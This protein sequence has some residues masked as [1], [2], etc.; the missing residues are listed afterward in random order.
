MLM[1]I[2]YHG[3]ED[4]DMS[5]KLDVNGLGVS[6]ATTWGFTIVVVGL[7]AHFTGVGASFMQS[8]DSLYP[9]QGTGPRGILIALIFGILQG[10]VT[11]A[12]IAFIYNAYLKAME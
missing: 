6:V 10:Y 5:H 3:N 4:Y 2:K 7:I 9:G 12:L 1:V 11:G 8:V